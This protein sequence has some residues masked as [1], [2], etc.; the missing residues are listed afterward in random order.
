MDNENI[1]G[2]TSI[3]DFIEMPEKDG[4]YSTP[5]IFRTTVNFD[6]EER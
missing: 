6:E 3:E 5:W 1:E 4:E 2:Q